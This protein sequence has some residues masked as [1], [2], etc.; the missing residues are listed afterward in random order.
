MW[1]ELLIWGDGLVW[2]EDAVCSGESTS[3]VI[4]GEN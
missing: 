1:G 4:E 2:G 3:I